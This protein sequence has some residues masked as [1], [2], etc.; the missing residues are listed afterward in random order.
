MRSRQITSPKLPCA[1]TL[2]I[3]TIMSKVLVML[4]VYKAQIK[5]L[6]SFARPP[7]SFS[8]E[9]VFVFNFSFL[10]TISHKMLIT[11]LIEGIYVSI[12]FINYYHFFIDRE[13]RY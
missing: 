4:E 6:F 8:E 3:R 13:V 5:W 10:S 1:S 7:V 11:Y 2:N 12:E 9:D